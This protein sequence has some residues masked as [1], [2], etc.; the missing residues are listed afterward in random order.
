V[1]SGSL[2][3]YREAG[4]RFRHAKT[5]IRHIS[6]LAF[7]VSFIF[8]RQNKQHVQ[9]HLLFSADRGSCHFLFFLSTKRWQYGCWQPGDNRYAHPGFTSIN[10]RMATWASTGISCQ[11][12]KAA[13]PP[14]ASTVYNPVTNPNRIA[15]YCANVPN[16]TSYFSPFGFIDY[17]ICD[18]V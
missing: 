3:C 18:R 14:G 6:F 9:V 10:K 8:V 11:V 4:F 1:I 2:A 7:Q 5:V 16:A 12:K 15:S 13:T 17:K